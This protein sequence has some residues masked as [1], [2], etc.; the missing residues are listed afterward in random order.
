MAH[1]H[2]CDVTG[3]MWKCDG[4]A[5]RLGHKEPSVCT[6]HSCRLPLEQGDHSH[7]KNLV[8]I[9]ACAEHRDEQ[10]RRRAEGEREFQ[11]RAAEFRFDEKWAKMKALP[12]GPEKDALA[13]EIVKWLFGD[14][15]NR[16]QQAGA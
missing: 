8:E 9:V 1:R 4:T 14:D 6:C 16:G 10:L 11:R 13:E 3:H 2:L 5:V 12:V 7:C 15:G